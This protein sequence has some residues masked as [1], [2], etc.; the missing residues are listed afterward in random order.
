MNDS[1]LLVEDELSGITTI[2]TES[3]FKD[4]TMITWLELLYLQIQTIIK[5]YDK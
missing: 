5:Y 2:S 3:N 4:K 1:V